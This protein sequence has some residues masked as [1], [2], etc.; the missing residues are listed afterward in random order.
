MLIELDARRQEARRIRDRATYNQQLASIA[1]R[2]PTIFN[3][4]TALKL[5][6]MSRTWQTE[7]EEGMG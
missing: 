3:N 1:K 6:L 4:P 2:Y 5:M 7:V